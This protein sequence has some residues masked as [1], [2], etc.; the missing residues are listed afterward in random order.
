VWIEIVL[1][2]KLAKLLEKL[3]RLSSFVLEKGLTLVT[4]F[5]SRNLSYFAGCG[6]KKVLT[7]TITHS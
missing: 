7:I 1:A 3:V 2:L 6:R 4:P 5:H